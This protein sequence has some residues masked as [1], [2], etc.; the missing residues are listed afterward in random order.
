MANLGTQQQGSQPTRVKITY[1]VETG[2][3]IEKRELPFVL[4]VLA[5]LRGN[6]NEPTSLSDQRFGLHSCG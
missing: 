3:S 2:G 4:G 5:D 1:D 6:T